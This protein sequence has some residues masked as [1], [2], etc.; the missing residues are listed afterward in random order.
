MAVRTFVG[1]LAPESAGGGDVQRGRRLVA[2]GHAL[3]RVQPVVGRHRHEEA[4]ERRDGA[5]GRRRRKR[6]AARAASRRTAH[7]VIDGGGGG[8]AARRRRATM[9]SSVGRTNGRLLAHGTSS[10]M[11]RGDVARNLLRS[12]HVPDILWV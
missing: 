10:R 5:G 1:A 4:Q 9:T 8:A 11:G 12:R 3:D 7:D 2:V 6:R